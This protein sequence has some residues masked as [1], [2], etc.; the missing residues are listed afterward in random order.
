MKLIESVQV[1]LNAFFCSYTRGSI[2]PHIASKI[3]G[4]TIKNK[5]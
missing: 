3:F 2:K 1:I 4:W 5:I